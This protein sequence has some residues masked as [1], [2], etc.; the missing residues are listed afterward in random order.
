MTI[1]IVSADFPTTV[2]SVTFQFS[3]IIVCDVTSFTLTS[4]VTD[5]SYLIG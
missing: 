1:K 3:Y 4:S 2:T 5:F